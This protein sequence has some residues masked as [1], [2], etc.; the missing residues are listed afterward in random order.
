MERRR[1]RSDRTAPFFVGHPQTG[2]HPDCRVVTSLS[3]AIPSSYALGQSK[4]LPLAHFR[5]TVLIID[6]IDYMRKQMG[7]LLRQNGVSN[8]VEAEEGGQA[9]DLLRAA[10]EVFGMI[11]SDL[12]MDPMSGLHLLRIL[13]TDQITPESLKNIPFILVTGNA[14]HGTVTEGKA[15]GMDGFIAKPFSGATLIKTALKVLENR[16]TKAS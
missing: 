4:P 8:V 9:F 5:Q 6:D 2:R 11:I 3:Y 7:Y 15:L 1:Q 12:E 13:R 16:Q 10:P 14:T